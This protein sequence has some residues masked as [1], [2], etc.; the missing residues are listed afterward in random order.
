MNDLIT[1]IRGLG[2]SGANL[3]VGASGAAIRLP[4][5][6]RLR[7]GAICATADKAYLEILVKNLEP[8]LDREKHAI[9]AGAEGPN[10]CVSANPLHR[11]SIPPFH[12]TLDDAEPE[13]STPNPSNGGGEKKER[14]SRSV[15]GEKQRSL[16]L[17]GVLGDVPSAAAAAVLH[18]RVFLLEAFLPLVW[19]F[20]FGSSWWRCRWECDEEPVAL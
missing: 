10:S 16:T 18:R 4:R 9:G 3:L 12:P 19:G 14:K 15:E 20:R 7:S 11:S 5:I 1:W 17:V 6:L 8:S 2:G 13:K